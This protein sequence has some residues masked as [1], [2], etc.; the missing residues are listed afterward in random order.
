MS[1]DTLPLDRWV[2]CNQGDFTAVRRGKIGNV[3][4]DQI[5]WG[6]IFDTYLKEFGLGKLYEKM[7]KTMQRK[8]ILECEFVMTGE[9]F[10]LTQLE[11]E[12]QKLKTMMMNKGSGITIDQSLIYLSKWLGH[13]VKKN[14]ITVKEYFYLVA[15]FEKYNKEINGKANKV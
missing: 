9:R 11:V 15:E 13:W 8:A 5:V 2:K 4:S 1:I 12:E 14:E 3:L 6:K 10:K 7:L